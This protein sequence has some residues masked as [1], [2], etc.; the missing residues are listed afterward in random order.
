MMKCDISFTWMSGL[1]P[2][3]KRHQEMATVVVSCPCK[4]KKVIQKMSNT[5]KTVKLSSVIFSGVVTLTFFRLSEK[6]YAKSFS[7][8]HCEEKT[9]ILNTNDL[10]Q[11]F[12]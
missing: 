10:S 4:Q 5:S 3:R 2:S 12:V 9:R 11:G 6:M 1:F 7:D 8:F